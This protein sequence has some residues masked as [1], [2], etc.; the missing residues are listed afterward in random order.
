[1]N[2]K[3]DIQA[4]CTVYFLGIGGIGMSA[5]ARYFH[6]NRHPVMGYDLTPSPLTHEL[7]EEGIMVKYEDSVDEEFL[8]SVEDTLVVRT[9]AVPSISSRTDSVSSSAPRF[10]ASSPVSTRPSA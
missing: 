3:D 4:G 9:P 5:L 8:L 1:M 10:W 2:L 6:A 7:E